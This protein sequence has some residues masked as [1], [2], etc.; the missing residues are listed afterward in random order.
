MPLDVHVARKLTGDGVRVLRDP[1][2]GTGVSKSG[3]VDWGKLS[4]QQVRKD[5]PDAIVVFIGANEG[6]PLKGAGGREVKCCGPEWAAIYAFRVRRMMNTYRQGGAARVYWL[7]LP[8][9]R[10]RDRQEIANSVNAA[11]DVASLPYRS[12]ARVLDLEPVFTP[13]ERYRDAMTVDGRRKIVRE[14][15]GIHLNDAGA[16][17]AAELVL[18]AVRR[19]FGK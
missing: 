6:F 16:E 2:I 7:T 4:G 15:D 19:D 5:R 1:H 10:A 11:I 3:F 9:P 18:D 13:G 17:L 8:L 12:S 14:P